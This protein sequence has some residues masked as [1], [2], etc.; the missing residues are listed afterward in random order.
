M[1]MTYNHFGAGTVPPVPPQISGYPPLPPGPPAGGRQHRW[2]ILIAAAAVGGMV[3]VAAVTAITTQARL[4][5]HTAPKSPPPVTVTVPPPTPAAPTPLPT[6]QAD[7]QTCQQGWIPAGQAID[8]A[9]AALDVLPKGMKVADPAVQANP[10]WANAVGKAGEFYRNASAILRGQIAP[11]TT[12]VLA[13]A[14]H[15]AVTALHALGDAMSPPSDINGNAGAIANA[16]AAQVG[17]LC[18]RLAP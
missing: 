14:A 15:T 7:R 12:P 2:P 10:E 11:G 9:T 3:A 13:E 5:A 17:V 4:S 6:A 1:P 16:A 18:Q 8:S